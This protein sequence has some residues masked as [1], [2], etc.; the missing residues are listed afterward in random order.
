MKKFLNAPENAVTDYLLG[1]AAAHPTIVKFDADQRI[2]VRAARPRRDKVGLI[3]GGGSGCEPL[4]TGFVG[5]GM[6]DAACPG[7]IFTSPVPKQIVAATRAADGGAGVLHVIKN[8]S[9]EVMNFGMATE[10]LAFEGIPIDSVLINDDVS[11][12]D[13]PG[14][15]GRRGLGA[16][17]L[18]EKIAGGAAE[19]GDDLAA[20]TRIARRV[21]ERA[22]TFG[23]GLSSCTP[24]L[25][26]KPIYDLPD[27]E[28]EFGIGISGEPGRERGAMQSARQ[29]ASV[30]VANV[31]ADLRPA[32][33]A[34][35]LVMVNGMGATPLSE[36]YVLY[37]ECDRILRS[38]GLNPIR[39]L[40]GNFVTSLDQAGAALTILELDDDMTFLWDAPV[41]TPSVTWGAGA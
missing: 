23:V 2:I 38:A 32:P 16:T 19:R 24:P 5:L 35:V 15:A 29:I 25:R 9:G 3:A 7:E 37:G 17:V 26:G 18:V 8:F 11:I 12:P 14:T 4:H 41:R 21:N 28:I 33:S 40:V 13:L 34:T 10:L 20:V 31:L 6:L 36:L 27:G 30:M 1:F 22:R 39:S